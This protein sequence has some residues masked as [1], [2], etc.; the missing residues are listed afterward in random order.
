MIKGMQG[1]V[2]P[3]GPQGFDGPP[4]L[5]G[6]QGEKGFKGETGKTRSKLK[7]QASKLTLLGRKNNFKGFKNCSPDL[8]FFYVAEHQ[9]PFFSWVYIGDFNTADAVCHYCF[10][11]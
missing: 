2:G 10:K 11:S 8:L 5:T 7:H 4:G 3:A 1:P 9:F 6:H